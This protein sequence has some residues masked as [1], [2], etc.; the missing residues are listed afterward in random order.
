MIMTF[1]STWTGLGKYILPLPR[2]AFDPF[3]PTALCPLGKMLHHT[4]RRYVRQMRSEGLFRWDH[5]KQ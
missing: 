3:L 1:I 4:L 2:L 5:C